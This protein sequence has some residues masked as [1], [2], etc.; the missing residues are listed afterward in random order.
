MVCILKQT[1]EI[2]SGD[3]NNDPSAL[4]M[5]SSVLRARGEVQ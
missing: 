4:V 1:L 2:N 3:T 5:K